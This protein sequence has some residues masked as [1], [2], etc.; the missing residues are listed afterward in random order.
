MTNGYQV[1]VV[2]GGP[3]G[4]MA[5]GQAAQLGARTL[6]L[7]KMDRP[8]RK[9]RITG[10]GRCN[11][12]NSA[13]LPEFIAHFGP[14]GRFLRQ[15]FSQFFAPE[16]LAFLGERGVHT[17]TERGG[18]IFPTSGRAQGIADAL[19]RWVGDTGASIRPRS[20]VGRLLVNAG[21][22]VG[23]QVPCI[24]AGCR[25]DVS[26]TPSRMRVYR[27]DRVIIATGGASYPV[28]GSTGDGYL[29]AGSAG[30]TVAPIQPALVPLVTA[31]NI[32]SRLQGLSLR[33]VEVRVLIDEEEGAR[34]LGEMLFTHYGVSGP[35]ILTFSKQIV[36]ALRLKRKVRLSI[37]LKPSLDERKLDARI[38]RDLNG[39]GR[40]HFLALLRELLPRKLIPVC[41]DLT[42]ISPNKA[43]HQITG[44]ERSRLRRWLKN[45]RVEVT[46]H[47]PL[48][49]AIITAGGVDL[50]E[51][52][53]RTMAS[54]L[55]SG[56]HFAGE[57]LD[58]DADTGGYNLQAAFS[59]GWVA[60][61]S[62]A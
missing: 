10:K 32:A 27:A 6:L 23:V 46:G 2:G 45:F 62:A 29:F 5:A 16:L 26:A 13:P 51:I 52:D 33:N 58:L 4:L 18:R 54:R 24:P 31:G 19:L 38:L 59:T 44:Q 61:R 8:A 17:V 14:N 36:A 15:A 11:L 28:T 35:V 9:L 55:I 57:V 34:A 43:G 3:A 1:I 48:A 7:E 47:R 21:R 25:R 30:H 56:L 41:A 60:G 22:V 20:P 50:Q 39:F 49:E 42:R 40:R 12:T 37:D 53:P